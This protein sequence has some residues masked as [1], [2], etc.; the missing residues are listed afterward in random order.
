MK[1]HGKLA[2]SLKNKLNEEKRRCSGSVKIQRPITCRK[3]LVE[4]RMKPSSLVRKEIQKRPTAPA[5]TQ[6]GKIS[7]DE[8]D[9]NKETPG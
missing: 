2:F 7:N 9:G 6:A 1:S 4:K 8:R 3:P 5:V